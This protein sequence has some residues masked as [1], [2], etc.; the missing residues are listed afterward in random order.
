MAACLSRTAWLPLDGR[1][2]V[3]DC[4]RG[5]DALPRVLAF[6]GPSG[7][8]VA[9]SIAFQFQHRLLTAEPSE[10]QQQQWETLPPPQSSCATCAGSGTVRESRSQKVGRLDT[11]ASCTDSIR[12]LPT[13]SGADGLEE[14]C[15]SGNRNFKTFEK[16]EEDSGAR[17]DSLAVNKTD[18]LKIPVT[19]AGGALPSV[20]WNP[21]SVPPGKRRRIVKT[22]VSGP[23]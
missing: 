19:D 14:G 18:V 10:L 13:T 22:E 7:S 17:G 21:W 23:S 11:R 15:Q 5:Y 6:R 1:A 9:D 3:R 4:P 16:I 12:E 2:F 20:R 8:S